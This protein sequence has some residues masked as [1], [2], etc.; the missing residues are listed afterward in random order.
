MNMIIF[1]IICF[2]LL[3]VIYISHRDFDI[4]WVNIGLTVPIY[5]F[6]TQIQCLDSFKIVGNG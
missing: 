5:T 3:R 6:V 2:S 4:F 1:H